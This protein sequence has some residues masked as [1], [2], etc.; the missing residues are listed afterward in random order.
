MN[1]ANVLKCPL[2]QHDLT[3]AVASPGGGSYQVDCPICGPYSISTMLTNLIGNYPDG[4][5]RA[6]A[7]YVRDCAER[8]VP[9]A[10]LKTENLKEIADRFPSLSAPEKVDRLLRLLANDTPFPSAT[11]KMRRSHYPLLLRS[12]DQEI[13]YLLLFL[14]KA[15]LLERTREGQ[16]V[17]SVTGWQKLWREQAIG[18]VSK[19]GFVAMWFDPTLEDVWEKGLAPGIEDAGCEAI[20]ID[21]VHHNDK[22]CDR[23]VSEIRRCGFVIADVTGHRQGVYFEAGF[24][25]GLG[26]PVI[27][28]CREEDLD[29]AH[30]DTRQYNHI[31]WKTPT[32]LRAKLEDRIRATILPLVGKTA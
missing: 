24:A 5:R 14:T 28:T 22:I 13:E 6:A 4:T 1:L 10:M 29:Q 19:R 30:F 3:T 26:K 7:A 8:G 21:R 32:D 11:V 27:W 2:M 23:I 12:T 18:S 25:M 15:D 9:P 16:Y 17:V 31:V 20:R